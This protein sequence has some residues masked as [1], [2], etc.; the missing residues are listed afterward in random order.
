MEKICKYAWLVL[1]AVV[2]VL[3]PIYGAWHH[4][5]TVAICAI[6][7]GLMGGEEPAPEQDPEEQAEDTE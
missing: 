4:I 1:G 3:I 7:G 5:F 2:A 6:M